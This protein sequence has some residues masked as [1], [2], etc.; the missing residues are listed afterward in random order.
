MHVNYI[1]YKHLNAHWVME[2]YV[3]VYDTYLLGC[4]RYRENHV[5]IHFKL[6][7]GVCCCLQMCNSFVNMVVMGLA[8]GQSLM[9]VP[10]ECYPLMSRNTN[11]NAL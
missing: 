3:G 9:V 2:T 1:V 5:K 10:T 11:Y 4:L 8:L 7:V 6:A